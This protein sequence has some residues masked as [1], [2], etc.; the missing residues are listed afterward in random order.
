MS[1]QD[2]LSKAHMQIEQA[3][4]LEDEQAQKLID[5]MKQDAETLIKENETL[6]NKKN[7]QKLV[8]NNLREHNQALN[9]KLIKL[10]YKLKNAKLQNTRSLTPTASCPNQ[11]TFAK[12][13]G[14][15][16]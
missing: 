11:L 10:K 16:R 9:Q 13:K 6:K 7:Q 15:F 4:I 1:C 3:G 2:L 12:K 5:Q 14:M 8:I